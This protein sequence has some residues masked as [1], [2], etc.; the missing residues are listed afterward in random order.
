MLRTSF[1]S[2]SN[3][4]LV[5]ITQYSYYTA[6]LH[7]IH[8]LSLSIFLLLLLLSLFFFVLLNTFFVSLFTF[9]FLNNLLA[10]TVLITA[11]LPKR[12]VEI[13]QNCVENLIVFALWLWWQA[14]AFVF[15]SIWPRWWP[16]LEAS[17]VWLLFG[18]FTLACLAG[19]QPQYNCKKLQCLSRTLNI[20]HKRIFHAQFLANPCSW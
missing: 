12:V 11:I 10:K 20:W 7:F 19:G 3:G 16:V 6:V 14:E 17:L 9:S 15:P 8:S 1:T 5:I 18:A 13:G 2:P 4:N